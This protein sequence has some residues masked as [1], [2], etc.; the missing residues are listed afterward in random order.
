MQR[1]RCENLMTVAEPKSTAPSS[2]PGRAATHLFQLSVDGNE[3]ISAVDLATALELHDS[4]RNLFGKFVQLR[5]NDLVRS[6]IHAY[7]SLFSSLRNCTCSSS[8]SRALIR[9]SCSRTTTV[10]FC[11]T[12]PPVSVNSRAY[13]RRSVGE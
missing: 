11:S 8:L 9:A 6:G 2:W 13:A 5:N 4:G 7:P 12:S 3:P 10:T 1:K